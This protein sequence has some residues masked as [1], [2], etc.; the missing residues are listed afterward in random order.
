[1][2]VF[3]LGGTGSIGSPIVRALIERGHEVWALARSD[4]SASKLRE[5]GATAMA[6][7][8]AAPER[9]TPRLPLIDAVIHAACGFGNEM[10]A[11]DARLLDALL[12]ALAAQPK[13]P[14]F[15]YTGGGWLFGAT[16]DEVATEATPF[17][18]VPAFAWMVPQ[19]TR[20]LGSRDVDG[21]VI[22][23][24]MVYTPDG[25]VFSRFARDAVDR[26]AVRVV[27]SEQVRWPLVHGADLASL[28]ALALEHAPVRSSY[29]GA[30]ID[31]LAVGRIARAFARRF[32][33]SHQE[34][35]IISPD[36][37]AAELGEWAR[38]YALDQ[39]LSGAKARRDLGWAPRHLDPESEIAR[40][41]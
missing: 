31:G 9:W 33:T 4:A 23:P 11:I 14:R 36:A 12:P 40:L 20:I 10:A 38:G 16:G 13:R 7:D 41:P 21:I 39:R 27:G 3:I 8:I 28:Y 30:G 19:L 5:G 35:Q 25:G 24:A 17:R 37:I 6:G 18:P 22:H 2:R 32:R 26:D 29:I 15:I 34:P 1:L